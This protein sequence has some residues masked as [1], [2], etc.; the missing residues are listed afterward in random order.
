MK[1]DDR[2]ARPLR[3]PPADLRM[4]KQA[5][6]LPHEYPR[7]VA[8][9]SRHPAFGAEM[10]RFGLGCGL[11]ASCGNEAFQR[12]AAISS[13]FGCTRRRHVCPRVAGYKLAGLDLG[14]TDRQVPRRGWSAG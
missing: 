5:Q 12:F 14:R 4:A 13:G 6:S 8:F 9:N 11:P 2:S 7:L 3:P 1:L 10:R